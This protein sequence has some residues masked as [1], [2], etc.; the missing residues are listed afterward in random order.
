MLFSASGTI[1]KFNRMGKLAGF[2]LPNQILMRVGLRHDHDPNA[3]LPKGFKHIVEQGSVTETW[4]EGLSMFHNPNAL[5]PIDPEMFPGIAHHFLGDG[6][7]KSLLPEFHPYSSFTWNVTFTD[8]PELE[9]QIGIA[10][11]PEAT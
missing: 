11:G 2:G 3:S 6:Q 8:S 9:E 5:H 7:V 4:A 1:S 10:K